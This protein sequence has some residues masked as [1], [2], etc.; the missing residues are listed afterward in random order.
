VLGDGVLNAENVALKEVGEH[1]ASY[2]RALH[3]AEAKQV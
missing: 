3:A 2:F 1:V